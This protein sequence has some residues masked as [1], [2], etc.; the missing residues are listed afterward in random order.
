MPSYTES[1]HAA[2]PL[3]LHGPCLPTRWSPSPAERPIAT[4]GLLCLQ[5]ASHIYRGASYTY[6]GAF[7][8][9]RG[10]ICLRKRPPIPTEGLLYLREGPTIPTAVSLVSI[11]GPPLSTYGLLCRQ[12]HHLLA[13]GPLIPPES[14]L[15]KQRAPFTCK[16]AS[17]SLRKTFCTES[18]AGPPLLTERP[19]F[20]CL[21]KG[22]Q[23]PQRDYDTQERGVI[24]QSE[25]PHTPT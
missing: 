18:T 4:K 20:H 1:L 7:Y 15:C 24:Y 17:Y 22:L 5:C 10:L 11:E 23:Y 8:I 25:G 14:L 21:Q 19:P 3:I 12:G 13:E 2:L 6:S 9:Y 16:G